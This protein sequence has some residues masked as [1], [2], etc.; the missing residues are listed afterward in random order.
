[1][2]KC[3]QDREDAEDAEDAVIRAVAESRSYAYHVPC[4]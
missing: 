2:C 3:K 4:N 1:L